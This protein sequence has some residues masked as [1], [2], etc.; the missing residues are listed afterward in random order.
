MSKKIDGILITPLGGDKYG[1][2]L[3]KKV[4]IEQGNLDEYYKNLDCSLF[5]VVQLDSKNSVYVDDE[6]LFKPSQKFF[7]LKKGKSLYVEDYHLAGKGLVLGYDRET[8]DSV[9]TSLT[10]KDILDM[11][12]FRND[13]F[14]VSPKMEFI[15]FP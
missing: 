8:G 5:D 15:S 2:G 12:S 9:S 7:T 13:S 3:V 14:S 1:S 4:E 10:E 11:I 6:G